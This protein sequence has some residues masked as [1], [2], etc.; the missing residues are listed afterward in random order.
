MKKHL[1]FVDICMTNQKKKK[2]QPQ[3]VIR[4][5]GFGFF[6]YKNLRKWKEVAIMEN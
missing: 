4:E 2:N 3:F 5:K 6:L 1:Y